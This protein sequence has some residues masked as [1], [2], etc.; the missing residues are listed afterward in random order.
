MNTSTVE[1]DTGFVFVSNVN[2]D[3]TSDYIEINKEHREKKEQE[4]FPYYRRYAQYV[5]SNDDVS[6]QAPETERNVEL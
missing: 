4:K 1:N 3:F 6:E 2:F 5:L